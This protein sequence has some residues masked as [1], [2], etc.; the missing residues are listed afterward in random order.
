MGLLDSSG[1]GFK[2]P[3]TVWALVWFSPSLPGI[4]LLGLM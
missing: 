1:V 2:T 3:S 4:L